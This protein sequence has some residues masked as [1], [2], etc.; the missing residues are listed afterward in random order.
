M[1]PSY[2]ISLSVEGRDCLV[3][4]GGQVAARKATELARCGA[5]VL[6]VAPAVVPELGATPGVR[7]EERPYRPGDVR[8]RWLVVAATDDRSV[9]RAVAADAEAAGVWVNAVDDPGACSFT[10]PAILRRGPVVVAV[11]TE[12]R[13]PALAAWL[14]DRLGEMVGPEMGVAA[15]LLAEARAAMWDKGQKTTGI[16]WRRVLNSD[17]L[18]L[19]RAGETDRARERLAQCLSSS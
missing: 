5:A 17:M 11:S 9:N 7:V 3:V 1:A 13:S 2:P 10:A 8:G 14:R 12:G 6:V 4:G 15:E 18:E 16:D 19:V